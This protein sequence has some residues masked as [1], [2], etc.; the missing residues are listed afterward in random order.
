MKIYKITASYVTYCTA[1]VEAENEELAY[2]M[3]N[4]MDGGDFKQNGEL[5]NWEIENVIEVTK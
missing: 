2:E 4:E 3:A 1:F 5:G